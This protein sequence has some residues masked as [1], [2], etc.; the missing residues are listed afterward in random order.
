MERQ[1]P[2]TDSELWYNYSNDVYIETR[3]LSP[4][5]VHVIRTT[6]FFADVFDNS[7]ND[8]HVRMMREDYG[9]TWRVWKE[10]PSAEDRKKYKWK[11]TEEE[12][13]LRELKE[14]KELLSG[15]YL[16]TAGSKKILT[17]EVKALNAR[18]KVIQEGKR[19]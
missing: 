3:E 2:M 16:E 12:K 15:H 7:G 4:I 1:K 5:L 8:A 19:K 10:Y 13:I 14:L 18:L 9:R 17:D 11:E 6:K